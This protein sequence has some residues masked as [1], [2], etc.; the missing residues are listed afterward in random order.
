M[1]VS[2]LYVLHGFIP[3]TGPTLSVITDYELVG[4]LADLVVFPAGHPQPMFLA[5]RSQ[6]PEVRMTTTQINSVL[7]GCGLFGVNSGLSD[8]Y[9]KK[10]SD[11]GVRVADATLEHLRFRANQSYTYWTRVGATHQESATIDVRVMTGFDGANNPLIPAGSLALSGTPA[12]GNLYTLGP[13]KLNGSFIPGVVGWDLDL[14]VETFEVASDGDPFT[15]FLAIKSIAPEVVIRTKE[16]PVWTTYGANGAAVTALDLFLRRRQPDGTNFADGSASHVKFS[17]TAGL[18]LPVRST[19][20]DNDEFDT[21]L[22]VMLRAPDAVTNVVTT[23][24]A[25][26]V[27]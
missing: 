7:T 14:R 27:A 11:L 22:R 21:E 10:V 18:L 12:H 3:G 17:A 5:S 19:A 1:A 6:V 26:T 9:W 25:A 15:T 13:V 2:T 24:N 16:S 23:S 8:F 4:G 20:R